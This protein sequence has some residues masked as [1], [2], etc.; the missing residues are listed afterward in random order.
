MTKDSEAVRDRVE[1]LKVQDKS[2]HGC[3][4][5]SFI[6][7]IVS[8]SIDTDSKYSWIAS[9]HAM[10]SK[11]VLPH[12]LF[13]C[14]SHNSGEQMPV[15]NGPMIP[16]KHLR[17]LRK[18]IAAVRVCFVILGSTSLWP[19]KYPQIRKCEPEDVQTIAGVFYIEA[20]VVRTY[21]ASYCWS[22]ECLSLC[23]IARKT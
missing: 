20:L 21:Q 23:A 2:T 9:T 3:A 16:V 10:R 15:H 19:Q 5:T 14:M 18:T 13:W 4:C 17:R 22:L 8:P 12:L 6:G 11:R 1:K 7:D